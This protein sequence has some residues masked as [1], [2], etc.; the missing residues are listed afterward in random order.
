MHLNE[1]ILVFMPLIG[2]LIIVLVAHYLFSKPDRDA[3]KEH[4]KH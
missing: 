4:L 1:D 3:K 2:L